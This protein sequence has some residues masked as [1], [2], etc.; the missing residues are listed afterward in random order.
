MLIS[1]SDWKESIS[2]SKIVTVVMTG[3]WLLDL[4]F[5]LPLWLSQTLELWLLRIFFLSFFLLPVFFF[6]PP[7]WTWS[8]VLYDVGTKS[9]LLPSY[10]APSRSFL[11]AGFPSF[12]PV[13]SS[14]PTCH[15]QRCWPPFFKLRLTMLSPYHFFLL[16]PP[17]RGGPM[18]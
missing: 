2:H 7:R 4:L 13:C 15:L 14:M 17:G 8:G 10:T 6:F 12:P 16:C 9:W 3:T 5:L 11:N 1:V 18:K